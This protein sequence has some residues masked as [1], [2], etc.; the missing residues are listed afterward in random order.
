[1]PRKKIPELT[2]WEKRF[3]KSIKKQV[4]WGQKLSRKQLICC[5]QI[6]DR[7]GPEYALRL[8]GTEDFGVAEETRGLAYAGQ[9]ADDWVLEPIEF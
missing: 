8:F 3:S 9:V 6:V 4:G 1:M 7:V 2:P 5:S